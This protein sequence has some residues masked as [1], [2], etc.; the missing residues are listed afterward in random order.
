MKIKNILALPLRRLEVTIRQKLK[1]S[2][3]DFELLSRSD[4][5]RYWQNPND[6]KNKSQDYLKKTARSEFLL[7]LLAPYID[8]DDHIL[9]IG[10]NVGRNLYFLWKTGFRHL[11]G[12]EINSNALDLLKREFHDMAREIQLWNMAV[13]D[14]IG[15][16]PENRFDMTFTMATL[17]HIHPDS[18]WVFQEI[19]RITKKYIVTIEDEKAAGRRHVPR[20]YSKIFSH[21]GFDL[22]HTVEGRGIEGSDLPKSFCARVFIRNRRNIQESHG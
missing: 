8:S 2:T 7:K 22:I 17:Q 15:E 10:C 14:V 20:D 12:I 9:E 21:F 13:E 3:S 19:A 18:E 4:L 16:I 6:G 1:R 11:A 5:H